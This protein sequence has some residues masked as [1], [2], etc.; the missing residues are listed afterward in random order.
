VDTPAYFLALIDIYDRDEY[1]RYLA[2]YDEVFSRFEGEVLAVDEE[3]AVLEGEWSVDRTVLIRFPSV[4]ALHAWY[5]STE[6]QRLAGHRRRGSNGRI[7]MIHGRAPTRPP[8]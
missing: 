3:P 8:H 2:G 4:R 5:N 7:A 6:Y 1:E